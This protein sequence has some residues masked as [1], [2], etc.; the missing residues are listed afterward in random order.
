MSWF[1]RRRRRE[2]PP[3]LLPSLDRLA[4]LIER[5]VAL[6]DAVA[7]TPEQKPREPPGEAVVVP[8]HDP[9]PVPDGWVAFVASPDG[10][11]LLGRDGPPPAGGAVL[12]LDGDAFTVLRLGPSPFP[13]DGRRC[14]FLER[15]EPPSAERTFD[16]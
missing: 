10:Y 5:V 11:R 1:R 4:E 3:V 12:E 9:G 15:K 16:R 14:A 2:P 13:G 6:L 7:L 8:Q